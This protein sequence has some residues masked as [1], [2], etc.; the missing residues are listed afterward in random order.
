MYMRVLTALAVAVLVSS[1]CHATA[2]TEHGREAPEVARVHSLS[3]LAF[4]EG[5]WTGALEGDSSGR[6]VD[7]LWS[8][9]SGANITGCFRWLKADGTPMV[10]EMLAIA[11]EPDAIRLR[12]MHF[13]GALAPWEKTGKPLV[14]TLARIEGARAEFVGTSDA[15]DLS[16]ITYDGTTPGALRITVEFASG[17]DAS[18]ARVRPPLVFALRRQ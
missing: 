1:P 3:E 15:G 4:L 17:S 6:R 14:L 8:A 16:K 12:L 18:G 10:L 7:E 11:E 2:A 5:A 13:S 9:P